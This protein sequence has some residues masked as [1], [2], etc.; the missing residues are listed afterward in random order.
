MPNPKNNLTRQQWQKC[1]RCGF[2]FPM[3]SLQKQKGMLLDQK[4]ID[5]L[6]IERRQYL[7][8]EILGQTTTEGV[9]MRVVDRGFYEGFD[10]VNR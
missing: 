7:I 6:Q 9:D 10:E 2:L 4:C 5:N 3:G 8:M 1:D